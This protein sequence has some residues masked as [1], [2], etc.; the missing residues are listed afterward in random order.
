MDAFATGNGNTL[1]F[2]DARDSARIL[3]SNYGG[4]QGISLLGMTYIPQLDRLYFG[5]TFA[6]LMLIDN[7][8]S[9]V[10]SNPADPNTFTGIRNF[11]GSSVTND[12]VGITGDYAYD[13]TADKLYVFGGGGTFGAT[14]QIFV[15]DDPATLPASGNTVNADQ[16]IGGNMTG[17][18]GNLG[19]IVLLQR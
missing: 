3:D 16:F 2:S 13:A 12:F 4:T 19:D 1:A 7:P 8:G 17:L 10:T 18:R 9:L 11:N 14:A 15:Y 5:N 6:G